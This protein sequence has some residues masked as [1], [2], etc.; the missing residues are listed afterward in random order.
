[1]HADHDGSVTVFAYFADG[2]VQPCFLVREH[3]ES[4]GTLT[5]DQYVIAMCAPRLQG[6][7]VPSGKPIPLGVI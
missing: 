4:F 1:M 6:S 5:Q 7:V 2:F 3:V